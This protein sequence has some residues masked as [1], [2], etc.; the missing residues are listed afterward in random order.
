MERQ[1]KTSS[2]LNFLLLQVYHYQ[3]DETV[4]SKIF[5]NYTSDKGLVC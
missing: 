3:N 2:K 1:T 5:S 4:Y